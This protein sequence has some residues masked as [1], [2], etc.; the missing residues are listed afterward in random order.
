[1][2]DGLRWSWC[3]KKNKCTINIT[4]L[5][6]PETIAHLPSQWKNCLLGNQSLVPK[7]LG[8]A[9]LEK[10]KVGDNQ[11]GGKKLMN[12]EVCQVDKGAAAAKSLQSCLALCNPWDGRPPGSPVPGILQERTLEWVAISFYNAWKWK[13]KVKSLSRVRLQATP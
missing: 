12:L 13:V 9:G 7:R 8:T 10:K 5:N 3:N 6:H 11:A 1:M 2:L 4:Y